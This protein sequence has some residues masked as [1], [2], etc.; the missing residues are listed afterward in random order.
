MT[1]Y[2]GRW[3]DYSRCSNCDKPIVRFTGVWR[4]H[5]GDPIRG[6]SEAWI[7]TK[8]NET[9]CD[10]HAYPKYLSEPDPLDLEWFDE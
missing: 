1:P 6:E 5:S 10:L 3:R 9:T 8:T 2:D 7:H 4:H